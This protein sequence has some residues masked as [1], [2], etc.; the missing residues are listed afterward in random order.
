VPRFKSS[1]GILPV[2]LLFQKKTRSRRDA[3]ATETIVLSN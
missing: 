2:V 1:A 3:G